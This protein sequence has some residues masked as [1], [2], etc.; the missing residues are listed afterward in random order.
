VLWAGGSSEALLRLAASV[1]RLLDD[2]ALRYDRKPFVPHV[3]LLRDLPRPAAQTV[4]RIEPPITWR[5]GAPVLLRSTN[6]AQ[7]VRY[8]ELAA[9]P[10]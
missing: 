9:D 4:S 3:T 6:E 2:L 8:T 1:R 10:G 5:A 7:G